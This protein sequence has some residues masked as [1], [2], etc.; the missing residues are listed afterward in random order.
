MTAES[1][2]YAFANEDNVLTCSR[3]KTNQ[4]IADCQLTRHRRSREA[5]MEAFERQPNM[6]TNLWVR[7]LVKHST[8]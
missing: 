8:E 3:Q 4:Y 7:E 6:P 1:E 5:G 2:F